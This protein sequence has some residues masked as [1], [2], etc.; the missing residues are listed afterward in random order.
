MDESR[1]PAAKDFQRDLSAAAALT[2][3]PCDA[4]TALAA[5]AAFPEPFHTGS[6]LWRSTDQPNA[7]LSYRVFPSEPVDTVERAVACGLL[8]ADHALLPLARSWADLYDGRTLH[9]CSFDSDFGLAKTWFYFGTK[10]PHD[11]I[12]DAPGVPVPLVARIGD[13]AATGLRRISF[14]AVDWRAG[15]VV[16]DFDIDGPLSR[17]DLDRYTAMAGAADVPDDLAETVVKHISRDYCVAL[18]LT[19]ADG[20]AFDVGFS[21]LD[22]P[23]S[24]LPRLAERLTRFFGDLPVGSNE[25]SVLG[26]SFGRRGSYVK[27]ERQYRGDIRTLLEMWS[28]HTN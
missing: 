28:K 23:V 6:V 10:R 14:A 7:P 18:A 1:T 27:A 26:W 20:D 9:S 21:V 12:L 16:L 24:A 4:E 3:A 19:A 22:V 17:V 2:G 15:S 13:F 11:E 8:P 25:F 5:F